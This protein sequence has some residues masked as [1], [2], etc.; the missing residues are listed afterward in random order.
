MLHSSSPHSS[1]SDKCWDVRTNTEVATT[2]AKNEW[3]ASLVVNQ[4]GKQMVNHSKLHR[5]VNCCTLEYLISNY[6]VI[7]NN[8]Y[9][10][11]TNI[12]T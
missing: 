1:E 7:T 6:V 4:N 9:Q 8:Q 5:T 10:V 3:P 12:L 2:R 11:C